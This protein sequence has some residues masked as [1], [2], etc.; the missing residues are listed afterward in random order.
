M[1]CQVARGDFNRATTQVLHLAF[2][3]EVEA[4]KVRDHDSLKGQ[5]AASQEKVRQMEASGTPPGGG[6]SSNAGGGGRRR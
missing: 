2:N 6:S 4:H 3:P 5:L 1:V